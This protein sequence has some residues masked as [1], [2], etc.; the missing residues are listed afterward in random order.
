MEVP[1]KRGLVQKLNMVGGRNAAESLHGLLEKL[2]AVIIQ[3][4]IVVEERGG[5]V[6]RVE[7]SSQVADFILWWFFHQRGGFLHSASL[8]SE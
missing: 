7:E 1:E 6:E 5:Q 2:P 8:R 4:V 3:W